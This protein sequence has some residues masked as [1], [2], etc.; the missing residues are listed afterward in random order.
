LKH[1]GDADGQ[2]TFT[3]RMPWGLRVVVS[4]LGF[5]PFLAPYELLIRPRW[6][7]V[8][9]LLIVPVIISLGAIIVGVI[10]ILAG[11]LG[12]NQTLRF[13]SSSKSVLYGY[14]T[15]ITRVRQK[16]YDFGDVRRIEIKTTDWDS[17]PPT[18]GLRVTFADGRKVEVGDFASQNE[19][20]GYLNRIEQLLQESYE[21]FVS[22][23]NYLQRQS[24]S[25][26]GD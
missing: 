26:A 19:A 14:E 1:F 5:L 23:G 11:V 20:Q 8:S 7:E 10:F 9:L 24:G 22:D 16:R 2:I 18:Y 3:E 15:A 6:Q 12:L 17:R 4:L 13:D 25:N 21:N